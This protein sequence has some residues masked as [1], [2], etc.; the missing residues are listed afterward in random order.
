VLGASWD[1]DKVV[2]RHGIRVIVA[3]STAPHDVLLRTV[4]RRNELDVSVSFAPRLFEKMTAKV[5]VDHLGGLPLIS[6]HPA[7]PKGWKFRL[8]Y[9]CEPVLAT[10]LLVAIGI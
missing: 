10:V 1:L 3:F 9:A 7:D 6:I 5:S 2:S 8:K 4:R